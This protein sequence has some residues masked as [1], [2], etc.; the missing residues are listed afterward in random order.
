MDKCA[1][2]ASVVCGRRMG[3]AL[4]SQQRRPLRRDRTGLW[5]ITAVG[6]LCSEVAVVGKWKHMAGSINFR[7]AKQP[8]KKKKMASPRKDDKNTR[9]R[10]KLSVCV[11]SAFLYY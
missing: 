9:A 3:I 6:T 2:R 10:Q 7:R 11:S 5:V 4:S 1:E 8:K